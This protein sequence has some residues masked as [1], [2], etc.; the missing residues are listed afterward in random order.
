MPALVYD[1]AIVEDRGSYY[2]V[3]GLTKNTF[4][5]VANGEEKHLKL[6]SMAADMIRD[7]FSKGNLV[8]LPKVLQFGEVLPGELQ[9]IKPQD[10]PLQAHK[11]ASIYKLK[12]LVTFELGK[13]SSF[14][15]YRYNVLHDE[16]AAEGYFI[17]SKNREQ[18]YI[19]IIEAGDVD[20]ISSL[21]KYLEA[22]DN[23]DR[24]V[25]AHQRIDSVIKLVQSQTTNE[26]V[27][28]ITNEFLTV[29]YS[30]E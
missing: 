15:L 19:E 21:E 24:A 22:R 4:D 7:E 18:K 23:L 16:L 26:E 28:R 1:L 9:I 14:D 17:T 6:S 30:N 8:R 13:I 3:L 10:D 5:A 27:D 11:N 25:S 12:Q 2:Q 29:F 20:L